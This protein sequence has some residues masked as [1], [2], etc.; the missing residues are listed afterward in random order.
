MR[1][2]REGPGHAARQHQSLQFHA[3]ACKAY[4]EV[5]LTGG[6]NTVAPRAG[7]AGV[8]AVLRAR[9]RRERPRP[10]QPL[11]EVIINA[12]GAPEGVFTR[13]HRRVIAPVPL[14]LMN[15]NHH[16]RGERRGSYWF[17]LSYR[18]FAGAGAA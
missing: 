16:L 1:I 5:I 11:A 9:G 18:D 6:V 14:P 7:D 10:L 12:R 8:T 3:R 13:I 2:V 17:M 4:D 15:A